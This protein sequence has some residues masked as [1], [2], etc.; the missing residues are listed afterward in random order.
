V[1]GDRFVSI[2]RG[3]P[4][5]TFRWRPTEIQTPRT[6]LSSEASAG[7]WDVKHA[8][9]RSAS[10]S[11]TST[12]PFGISHGVADESEARHGQDRSGARC[13]THRDGLLKWGYFGALQLWAEIQARFHV[14]AAPRTLARLEAITAKVR[15]HEG[16][17]VEPM[18]LAA[19]VLEKTTEQ[20]SD[21]DVSEVVRRPRR[22]RAGR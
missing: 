22:R 3:L 16:V 11:E 8:R 10:L 21:D 5:A 13:G 7:R 15:Q 1:H 4:F 20:I 18:Q 17:N 19:L 9:V 12:L 6:S 2:D 14:P